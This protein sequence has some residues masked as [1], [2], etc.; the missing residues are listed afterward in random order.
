M[1]YVLYYVIQLAIFFVSMWDYVEN[2]P[3]QLFVLFYQN[4]YLDKRIILKKHMSLTALQA[5]VDIW[6]EW[7][8][9]RQIIFQRVLGIIFYR[10]P[11]IQWII[12]YT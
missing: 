8:I 9:K 6:L 7:R 12:S 3:R 1:L 2:I 5:I 10:M 4:V 11:T